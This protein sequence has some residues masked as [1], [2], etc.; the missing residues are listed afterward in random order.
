MENTKYVWLAIE[1]PN[2]QQ[3]HHMKW[4]GHT[5]KEAAENEFKLIRDMIVIQGSKY[6]NTYIYE[7]E[8]VADGFTEEVFDISM[9]DRFG[10]IFQ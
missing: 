4:D 1:D 6:P 8:A 2:T 7:S 9:L 5:S 10:K 3:E